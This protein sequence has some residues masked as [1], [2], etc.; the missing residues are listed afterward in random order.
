MGPPD[1]MVRIGGLVGEGAPGVD[2]TR[3]AVEGVVVVD[4]EGVAGQEGQVVGFAGMDLAVELRG[5]AVGLGQAVEV[6]R[7]GRIGDLGE[8]LVLL[9]DDDHVGEAWDG[10]VGGGRRLG[11]R[12]QGQGGEKNH[13]QKSVHRPTIAALPNNGI[14]ERRHPQSRRRAPGRYT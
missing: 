14:A 1:R 13:R 8:V 3:M 10:A 5:L 9:D 2:E 12:G 7:H 11:G 6:G 4:A